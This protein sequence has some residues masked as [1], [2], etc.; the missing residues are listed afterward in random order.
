MGQLDFNLCSLTSPRIPNPRRSGSYK[1]TH[2]NATFETSR[3]YRVSGSSK[4]GNQVISSYGSTSFNSYK[5]P[6]RR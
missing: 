2:L 5:A 3:M 6:P 1:L 4:G